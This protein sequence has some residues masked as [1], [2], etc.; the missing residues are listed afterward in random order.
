ML[1][2]RFLTLTTSPKDAWISLNNVSVGTSP[3]YDDGSLVIFEIEKFFNPFFESSAVN[4][5]RIVR[6]DLE[7]RDSSIQSDPVGVLAAALRNR[8]WSVMASFLDL[9]FL[10]F[11]R[12]P[13]LTIFAPAD[14]SLTDRV[15][16]FTDWRSIFRRHVV[17]CKLR[18][19]DLADIPDGTRLRTYLKGFNINVNR[20]GGVLMLNDM[21]V[22]FPDM[23]YSEGIVVHGI[24]GILEMQ[25]EIKRGA[26]SSSD[27]PFRTGPPPESDKAVAQHYHFSVFRS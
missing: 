27:V 13:A 6:S 18:W 9:Q 21:S 15:G 12:R 4:S 3:V 23:F 26:E 24:G 8:G 5:K 7:C 16:N 17:P 14:D 20:S 10:G 1:P 2:S 22:V 19:S 11:R 25:K